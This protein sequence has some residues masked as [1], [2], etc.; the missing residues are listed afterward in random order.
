MNIIRAILVAL[1]LVGLTLFCVA[2]S[3]FVPVDLGF[4]QFDIWLPLLVLL[5]FVLGFL[6]VYLW[7]STDRILLKRRIAKLEQ[8]AARLEGEL[9]QA[10]VELLRPAAPQPQ[11]VPQ[12][13]PPPGT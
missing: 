7:L 13:A 10:R 2:N 6:P 1:L 3:Q 8:G 4:Q 12:P 5:A 11:A 9:S